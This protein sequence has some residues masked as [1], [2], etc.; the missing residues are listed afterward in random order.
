MTGNPLAPL[1]TDPKVK[2]KHK[3]QT[4]EVMH[5]LLIPM[6][7]T[8]I[9]AIALGSLPLVILGGVVWVFWGAYY[10]LVT[11]VLLP[12][13]ADTPYV[14]QHSNIEAMEMN[15]KFAEAAQAY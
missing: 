3:T 15:G 2:H 5:R 11:K 10:V 8:S 4:T 12:S 1:P 13:G 6:V 14:D 7:L 9:L